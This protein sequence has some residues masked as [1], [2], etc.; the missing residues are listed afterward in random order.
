MNRISWFGKIIGL[1]V[2]F[3]LS[4]T[5]GLMVYGSNETAAATKVPVGKM[6]I[7]PASIV[8]PGSLNFKKVVF[9]K[10]AG[11]NSKTFKVQNVG[12]APLALEVRG[13]GTPVFTI[14]Q[15]AGPAVL[16]PKGSLKVT[17]L[18]AP[19]AAGN[20]SAGFLISSNASMGQ[21]NQFIGLSGEA[22]GVPAATTTPTPTL[23][24]TPTPTS[25]ETP[26]PISSPIAGL[27][28]FVT[29]ASNNSL[30]TYPTDGNRNIAPSTAINGA[31]TMLMAPAGVA[32]DV[33]G[34]LY[35]TNNLGGYADGGTISVYPPGSN[36]NA[37]PSQIISGPNADL[38][39]PAGIAVDSAG[40]I[41][42]ANIAATPPGSNY[43]GSVNIYPP[44][45]NGN[46]APVAAIWGPD[47][48]GA[49]GVAVDKN[50]NIFVLANNDQGFATDD[51]PD[52]AEY[53]PGSNGKAIPTNLIAGKQTGLS[54]PDAKSIA[55]DPVNGD[56]YVVDSLTNQVL[57]FDAGSNG[58]V[59]PKAIIGG[60]NTLLVQPYGI[61]VDAGGAIYVANSTGSA[62]GQKGAG[63]ITIYSP[64]SGGNVA[65]SAVISAP[66]SGGDETDLSFPSGLAVGP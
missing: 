14:T 11:T 39:D 51:E 3:A 13:T 28:I 20:F 5:V 49:T 36:G 10:T 55:L 2:I 4:F 15:G 23:V 66:A 44:G 46:V 16:Q 37:T 65:P 21:V 45:S 43:Y 60:A 24:A 40:N 17:V 9:G 48:R 1:P 47:V 29:N 25:V 22:K 57:V 41:Y 50:G 12:T 34:N 53:A 59:S 58:D 27:S 42:V 61:A 30:T 8:A 52:I 31:N 26:T 62:T 18:F 63:S 19:D 33:L 54:N 6:S 32:I 56:I 35:V 38:S 64:G 7:A